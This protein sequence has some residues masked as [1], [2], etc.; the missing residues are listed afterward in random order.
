MAADPASVVARDIPAQ[1]STDILTQKLECR[2]DFV[3]LEHLVKRGAVEFV[4]KTIFQV[5]DVPTWNTWLQAKLDQREAR[6]NPVFVRD[7]EPV[8]D[9][10]VVTDLA[11]AIADAVKGVAEEL[12]DRTVHA[13][14]KRVL[15]P[16]PA[17]EPAP[18]P[19][20][21]VEDLRPR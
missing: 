14:V 11:V 20:P 6:K 8:L 10:K 17:P 9:E 2:V 4:N 18:A 13:A 5:K 7:P 15:D 16:E 19:E 21:I 3:E 1:F 12:R